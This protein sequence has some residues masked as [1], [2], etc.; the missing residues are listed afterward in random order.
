M[1][2]SAHRGQAVRQVYRQS[3]RF[4]AYEGNS[5]MPTFW[6]VRKAKRATETQILYLQNLLQQ[7][8]RDYLDES[9]EEKEQDILNEAMGHL[10]RLVGKV[11]QNGYRSFERLTKA[12]ASSIIDKLNSML[13]ELAPPDTV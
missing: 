6:R 4:D 1:L 12:Q 5:L 2:I 11:H 3:V 8:P 7:F 10:P 13:G 9:R